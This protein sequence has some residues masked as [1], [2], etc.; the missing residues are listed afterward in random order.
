MSY[1]S[2]H[3]FW[4]KQIAFL[5]LF[6]NQIFTILFL[7][8]LTTLTVSSFFLNFT[9]VAFF[10]FRFFLLYLLFVIYLWGCKIYD[11]WSIFG[12]L[13]RRSFFRLLLRIINV[14][15]STSLTISA[16]NWILLWNGLNFRTASWSWSDC[17]FIFVIEI[18]VII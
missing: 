1:E 10:S 14:L 11:I 2:W 16:Q 6:L 18:S 7:N 8:C 15:T 5:Y 12:S 4:V 3:Q 9:F 13:W 17:N